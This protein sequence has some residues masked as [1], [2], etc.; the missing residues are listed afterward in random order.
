MSTDYF[1]RPQ[2][3]RRTLFLLGLTAMFVAYFLV[4]LP[5]PGAGLQL[6]GIEIGEWIKFLGVGARRNLFY[7]PPIILGLCIA[8]WAAGWPNGRW[9]TWLARALAVGVALLAFPAV[10]AIQL[11]PPGEWAWRLGMIALVVIVAAA[12]ALVARRGAPPAWLWLLLAGVAAVGAV[13]PA[14]AYLSVLPVVREIMRRP[15]GIGEGVWLNSA[16]ALLVMAVALAEWSS[17]RRGAA[18]RAA[19]KSAAGP[20]AA[21]L[22]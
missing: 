17:A 8:L 20:E 10:A 3:W 15:V 11:E 9:Q 19:Q 7:L 22:E 16:G 14:W 4:W 1:A 18:R 12:G 21:A 6:I 13:L 5:G 2:G